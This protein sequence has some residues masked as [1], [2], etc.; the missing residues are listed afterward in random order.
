[1]PASDVAKL[2]AEYRHEPGFA[3]DGGG[4]GLEP[5]KRILEGAGQFLTADGI[6]IVEV[7]N[8]EQAVADAYPRLP[9]TWVEF[10][11][12]GDGVFV[13]SAEELGIGGFAAN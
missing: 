6:L 12:G 3:L 13:I 1:V 5:A 8:E 9:L 10:E 11:R 7:G 2:P 4:S